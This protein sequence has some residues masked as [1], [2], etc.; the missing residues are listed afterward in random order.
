M[1]EGTGVAKAMKYFGKR[2]GDTLVGFKNEWQA[3]TDEDQRQIR[4]GLEDGTLTY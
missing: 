1:P 2:A 3:L 4:Q